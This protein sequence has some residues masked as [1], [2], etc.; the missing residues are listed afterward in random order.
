M[1][2]DN[3]TAYMVLF[4]YYIGRYLILYLYLGIRRNT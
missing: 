2:F 4:K 1:V 3:S